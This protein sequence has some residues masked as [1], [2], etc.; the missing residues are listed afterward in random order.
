[1]LGRSSKAE[2]ENAKKRAQ[3]IIDK[4]ETLMRGVQIMCRWLVLLSFSVSLFVV[5]LG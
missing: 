3:A 2:H 4:Q 5:Q 1:M